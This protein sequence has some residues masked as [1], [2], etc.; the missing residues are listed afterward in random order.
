M[1]AIQFSFVVIKWQYNLICYKEKALF[2]GVFLD[3]CSL[4]T[5]HNPKLNFFECLKKFVF[6][7]LELPFLWGLPNC[8]AKYMLYFL[9]FLIRECSFFLFQ[10]C[11]GQPTKAT[12]MMQAEEAVSRIKVCFHHYFLY[13]WPQEHCRGPRNAYVICEI[14]SPTWW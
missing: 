13:F 2:F 7:N 1:T 12:R 3:Q 4:C 6:D 9:S 10:V 5:I 11:D 14:M 8:T